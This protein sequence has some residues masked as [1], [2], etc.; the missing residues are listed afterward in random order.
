PLIVCNPPWLPARPSSPVERAVYDPDNRMLRGF[1]EGL[2]AHLEPD[3]EGWLIPSDFAEH[4]VLRT[5]DA[6]LVMID[7]AGLQVIGRDDIK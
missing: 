5:R 7:A 2:T 1:L 3:G 4:L 6:L